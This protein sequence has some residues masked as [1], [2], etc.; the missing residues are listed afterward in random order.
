MRLFMSFLQL[1]NQ[2][3]VVGEMTRLVFASQNS[4]IAEIYIISKL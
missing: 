4:S 3:Y 1:L 2:N